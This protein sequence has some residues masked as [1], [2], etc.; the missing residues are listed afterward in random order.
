MWTTLLSVVLPFIRNN[1]GKVLTL[2]IIAF[3]A[4]GFLWY[5]YWVV[6]RLENRLETQKIE[7]EAKIAK[8]ECAVESRDAR[9]DNLVKVVE[10]MREAAAVSDYI[11]DELTLLGQTIPELGNYDARLD[12]LRT[13]AP[14]DILERDFRVRLREN[15]KLRSFVNR[16]CRKMGLEPIPDMA[17]I[18][19]GGDM[20]KE[21]TDEPQA[22]LVPENLPILP[23]RIPELDA[24]ATLSPP[25]AER[26]YPRVPPIG[27]DADDTER[28][29]SDVP[30]GSSPE[31]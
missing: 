25:S 12:Y 26:V 31:D 10:S 14:T 5:R 2:S 28:S 17:V 29:V 1:F 9:I 8:L 4:F 21:T 6:A 30:G 20:N 18:G 16:V 22:S 13:R 23:E 7:Y 27:P 3:L 24:P 11:R 15:D 19:V